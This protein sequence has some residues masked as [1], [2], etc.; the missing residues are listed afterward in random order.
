MQSLNG[1]TIAEHYKD[2]KF[3][4]NTDS[5]VLVEA[6]GDGGVI[7]FNIWGNDT[8]D[9]GRT[10]KFRTLLIEELLPPID[11]ITVDESKPATY[12][13]VTQSAKTGYVVRLYKDIYMNGKKERE[14]LVDTSRYEATP[15]YITVGGKKQ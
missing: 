15:R 14:V 2:L 11:V 13:N 5:P 4:N 12:R 8:R 10:F 3:R 9:K 6:R 7:T 1:C